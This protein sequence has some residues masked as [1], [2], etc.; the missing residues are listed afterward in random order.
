MKASISMPI[1]GLSPSG[2]SRQLSQGLIGRPKTA[3]EA[4]IR[5]VEHVLAVA[6][7]DAAVDLLRER[8]FSEEAAAR[9]WLQQ[10]RPEDA[11]DA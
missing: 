3:N 9:K 4:R 6:R 10:H 11:V 2:W 5:P 7:P 8:R 1:P